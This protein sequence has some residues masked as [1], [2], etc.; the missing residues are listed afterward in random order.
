MC[1]FFILL[2]KTSS[3]VCQF[4]F[5]FSF[6]KTF[7][8]S[9]SLLWKCLLVTWINELSR[10]K[11]NIR[12]TR[13]R[14]QEPQLADENKEKLPTSFC[15]TT[16]FDKFIFVLVLRP[17]TTKPFVTEF[18]IYSASKLNTIFRIIS[19]VNFLS[20]T[21]KGK[22]NDDKKCNGVPVFFRQR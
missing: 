8:M 17:S 20:N 4:I 7:Q 10:I 2:L 16:T 9:E 13:L 21:L 1:C 5:V 14:A 18:E 19:H 15:V 3:R 6:L 11:T 22:T 12:S